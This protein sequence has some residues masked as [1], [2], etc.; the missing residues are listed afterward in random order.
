MINERKKNDHRLNELNV[1]DQTNLTLSTLIIVNQCWKIFLSGFL[2]QVKFVHLGKIDFFLWYKVGQNKIDSKSIIKIQWKEKKENFHFVFAIPW[3]LILYRK[4]QT[5]NQKTK[6]FWFSIFFIN[7]TRSFFPP[8]IKKKNQLINNT[9][10]KKKQRKIPN[11][12][13]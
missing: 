9:M 2:K 8:L 4:T 13:H 12:W 7:Q 6:T 11:E 3:L 5:N 10:V 1:T